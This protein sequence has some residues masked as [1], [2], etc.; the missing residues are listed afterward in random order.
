MLSISLSLL[1]WSPGPSSSDGDRRQERPAEPRE[2]RR[3]KR[4]RECNVAATQSLEDF[5]AI[6]GLIGAPCVSVTPQTHLCSRPTAAILRRVYSP[7]R[8][9]LPTTVISPRP[10]QPASKLRGSAASNFRPRTRGVQN[11]KR[12]KKRKI[13]CSAQSI[14]GLAEPSANTSQR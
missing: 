13:L 1:Y 9:L 12:K 14:A 2:T 7:P 3:V 8:S 6:N 11:G 5:N 4:G 10:R